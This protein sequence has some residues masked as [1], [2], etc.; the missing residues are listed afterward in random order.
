M[1][2]EGVA[3][4]NVGIST[5]TWI[6][7]IEGVIVGQGSATL[8]QFGNYATWT[9]TIPL[10]L[11]NNNIE[12]LA[13]DT[14]GRTGYELIVVSGSVAMVSGQSSIEAV[15]TGNNPSNEEEIQTAEVDATADLV[16]QIT[17]GMREFRE[18]GLDTDNVINVTS[19]DIPTPPAEVHPCNRGYFLHMND[20]FLYS[21]H[22]K[23]KTGWWL[24]ASS[25]NRK[26]TD[27]TK[28]NFYW[29]TK[30]SDGA[31]GVYDTGVKVD[32]TVLRIGLK[33]AKLDLGWDVVPYNWST[34]IGITPLPLSRTEV[35]EV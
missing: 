29:A 12:I 5:V 21:Q 34:Y 35:C 16:Q 20:A 1:N 10:Q 13:T 17:A 2:I 18:F 3:V 4:D 11:G 6:N 14:S 30:I 22:K 19:L 15:P 27:P 31:Y 8:T 32:N 33:D 9:T 24:L 28:V 26:N 25:T 7:R 23:P